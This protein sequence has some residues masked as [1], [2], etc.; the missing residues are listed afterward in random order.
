MNTFKDENAFPLVGVSDGLTIRQHFA[1]MIMQ[2]IISNDDLR[3]C[4]IKD[5]RIDGTNNEN[6]IANFAVKQ[7]D[8]LIAELNK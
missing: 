1:S 8:A 4:L 3:L 5:M 6:Y 7:A 2:G